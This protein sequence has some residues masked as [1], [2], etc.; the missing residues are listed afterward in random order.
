MVGQQFEMPM[1]DKGRQD[2]TG[3]H[4]CEMVADAYPGPSAK[5]KVSVL[6]HR[7]GPLTRPAFRQEFVGIVEEARIAMRDPRA[8]KYSR[9]FGNLEIAYFHSLNRFAAK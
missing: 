5:R 3:F 1:P 8:Q 7:F 6:G 2:Q 4:H 9:P